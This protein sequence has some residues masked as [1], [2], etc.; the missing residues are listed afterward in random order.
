MVIG[1]VRMQVSPSVPDS[2]GETILTVQQLPNKHYFKRS[3]SNSSSTYT[4]IA[5]CHRK[6]RRS[7]LPNNA[8]NTPRKSCL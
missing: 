5:N 2:A 3:N 7:A 1:L 8:R 4:S 6:T